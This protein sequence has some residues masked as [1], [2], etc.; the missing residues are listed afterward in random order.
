MNTQSYRS[1]LLA[2]TALFFL[3]GFVASANHVLIPAC[4]SLFKLNQTYSMAV[5]LAFYLAYGLGGLAFYISSES[6]YDIQK[7]LG[8]KKSL[9]SGLFV[10]SVGAL[11]FLWLNTFGVE[12]EGMMGFVVIL[13]SLFVM[14]LGFSL[15]QI[16][17]NPYLIALGNEAFSAQRVNLAGAMNSLGTTLGP[18]LMGFAFF[19][20]LGKDSVE[21]IA[22]SYGLV[23][24]FFLFITFLFS[25][26]SLPDTEQMHKDGGGGPL[27][28]SA[29][30]V[31]GLPV[32][33]IYVGTEVTL[34]SNLPMLLESSLFLGLPAS[35]TVSYTSLY[36]G[37][38]MM[39]RWMGAVQVLPLSVGLRKWVKWVAPYL[40][41]LLVLGFMWTNESS[42]LPEHWEYYPVCM[43]VFLLIPYYLGQEKPGRT[44]FLLSLSGACSVLMGLWVKGP[45]GAL[46][47]VSSG[48]ACSVMWS[49]I[50]S[51]AIRGL[52]SSSARGSA[53]LIVM[54]TGG[55]VI[56]V[57]QGRISDVFDAGTGYWVPVIGFILMAGYPLW[58]SRFSKRF[59]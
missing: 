54:I 44:L 48:L 35:E 24:I 14:G 31:L 49:C 32:L 4:K 12:H 51:I 37:S 34:S 21:G 17:A 36:W 13:S 43:A 11:S 42:R 40:A 55:A 59:F 3:W 41:F 22:F 29:S 27:L 10:A 28:A 7:R 1:A 20:W 15:L 23:G 46:L 58:S 2:M 16:V 45:L 6:G 52:G 25:R 50:F 38:L 8:A 47:V 18:L 56:P 53:L 39:G 26:I 19:R 5:D 30:F 9:L 57:L 33:F